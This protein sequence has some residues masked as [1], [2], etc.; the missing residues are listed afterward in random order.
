MPVPYAA[1]SLSASDGESGEEM[2]TRRSDW[3]VV[4]RAVWCGALVCRTPGVC[5]SIRSWAVVLVGPVVA[6]IGRHLEVL[7]AVVVGRR[8]S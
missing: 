7:V 1:G 3:A 4:R 2:L 8:S 6:A 5:R